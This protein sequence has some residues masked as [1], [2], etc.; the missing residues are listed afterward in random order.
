MTAKEKLE[1]L[2][3]L[4]LEINR[5]IERLQDLY[6]DLFRG[7]AVLSAVPGA[8]RN[9]RSFEERM[10][11]YILLRDEINR[12]IDRLADEKEQIRHAID[13]LPDERWRSAVEMFYLRGMT[14]EQIGKRLGYDPRHIRRFLKKALETIR[15]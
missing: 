4:D 12:D 2:G 15:L 1:Q 13:A 14:A 8:G 7:S 5:K 10:E 6:A 11:R 3:F 9:N